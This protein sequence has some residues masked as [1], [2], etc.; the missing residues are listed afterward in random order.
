MHPPC[1]LPA[2]VAAVASMG[3]CA[4]A[5]RVALMPP[6]LPWPMVLPSSPGWWPRRAPPASG[7]CASS[8]RAAA[9]PTPYGSNAHASCS[10]MLSRCTPTLSILSCFCASPRRAVL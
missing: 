1:T 9:A 4:F 3:A 7:D 6:P 8:L 2:G 10:M 5:L